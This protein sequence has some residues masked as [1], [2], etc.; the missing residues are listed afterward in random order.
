MDP[1]AMMN[2]MGFGPGMVGG[3]APGF[4]AGAMPHGPRGGFVLEKA[5]PVVRLRG[6]PFNAGEAD[7]LEFFAGLEAVDALVVR[8]DGR[9]TG[10]AYVVFS[11]A[12]Q[13][14]F[15]LQKNRA[16]MGRRYIEVFRSKK[17]EYYHAVA[18]AVRESQTNGAREAWN[19]MSSSERALAQTTSGAYGDNGVYGDA[20]AGAQGDGT[21]QAFVGS[22]HAA[23]GASAARLIADV[24]DAG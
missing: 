8:R 22:H 18:A 14:D 10:E 20:S 2:P 12:V 3:M 9:T 24:K 4:G 16:G 1:T 19:A 15:A 21:Q 6:L 5:L 7:V 23:M 13:M 17:A 11:N